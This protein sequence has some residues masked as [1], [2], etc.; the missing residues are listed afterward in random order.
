MP[1]K[2]E[3]CGLNQLYSLRCG[4]VPVVRATGGLDDTVESYQARTGRGTGFKFKAYTGPALMRALRSALQ[5]YKTPAR[6]RALQR[7]GMQQDHSWEAS[8]RA[9]LAVYDRVETIT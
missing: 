3:P 6:W 5:V 2:Y 7:A 9:Y 4:T 8:A 1:S